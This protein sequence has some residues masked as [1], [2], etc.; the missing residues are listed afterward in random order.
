M[1]TENKQT[2]VQWSHSNKVPIL[3][4]GY[5]SLT[6]FQTSVNKHQTCPVLLR[7]IT[8]L[9]RHN[10]FHSNKKYSPKERK[11]SHHS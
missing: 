10:I 11:H 6:T 4:F 9:I 8:K 2:D 7:A 3:S 5:R 1:K